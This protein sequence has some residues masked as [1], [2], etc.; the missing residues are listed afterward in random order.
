MPVAQS[1]TKVTTRLLPFW[2]AHSAMIHDCGASTNPALTIYGDLVTVIEAPELRTTVGDFGLGYQ[3]CYS[4]RSGRDSNAYQSYFVV[5]NHLLNNAT[6]IVGYATIVPHDNFNLSPSHDIAVLLHIK[7]DRG[8][9]L[10]TDGVKSGASHRYTD[11]N[12]EDVLRFSETGVARA[13]SRSR[14]GP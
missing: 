8:C 1:F 13:A 10:P 9:E 7:L 6:C 12:F 2:A 14:R 4:Q 5:Y 3:W 11:A